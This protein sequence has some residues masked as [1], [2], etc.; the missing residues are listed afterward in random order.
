VE[1]A[2]VGKNE[3]GKVYLR[4]WNAGEIETLLEENELAEKKDTDAMQE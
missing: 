3:D 1:F 4:L 2:T